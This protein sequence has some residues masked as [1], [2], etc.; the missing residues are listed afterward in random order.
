VSGVRYPVR[1]NTHIVEERTSTHIPFTASC[2]CT[3]AGVTWLS[4]GVT[5]L[6]SIRRLRGSRPT[7]GS[8]STRARS[9]SNSLSTIPTYVSHI[10]K[11]VVS[12]L[13]SRSRDVLT[14]RLGLGDMRLVY[15]LG[16]GLKGLAHVPA[17]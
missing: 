7:D 2:T 10:G 11:D 16:L 1:T 9:S 8:T 14:S 5:V 13:T 17:H 12:V 15:R 6:P 4:C 3:A